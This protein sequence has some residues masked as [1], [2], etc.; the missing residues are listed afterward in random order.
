MND[1]RPKYG[2]HKTEIDGYLFDSQAEARR[3]QELKL[4]QAAGEIDALE[5]QPVYEIMVGERHI[6]NYRADFKYYDIK[7][8]MAV[9]EDVKGYRTSV[10]RLKKKLVEAL[11]HVEI[12]EVEA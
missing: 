7:K 4:M 8:G 1:Q 10:Y 3:Y 9:V 11:Y 5:L 6:C 2:N 12:M